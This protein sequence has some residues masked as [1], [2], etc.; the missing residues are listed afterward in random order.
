MIE[1]KDGKSCGLCHGRVAFSYADCLRCHSQTK[2]NLP[3]GVLINRA[4]TAAS[5]Q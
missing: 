1:M 5:T 2:E 4:G 3:Q